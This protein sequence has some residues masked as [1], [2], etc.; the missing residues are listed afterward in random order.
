MHKQDILKI[1]AIKSNAPN[2]WMVYKRQQNITNKEI[3]LTKQA[4]YQNSF[5]EHPGYSQKTWQTINE[6]TSRKSGKMSVTSLKINGLMITD[7]REISNKFNNH[8]STISPKLASEIDSDSG[9]Y[10][11]Y[12][13][14]TDK[15]FHLHPTN[16]SKVFSLMNKLNKLKQT[17]KLNKFKATSISARLIRECA[18][19]ICVPICHIFNQSISQGKLPEDWKSARVTPF[20]KQG[21]QDDVNNYPPRS[22]R[23][24]FTNNYMPI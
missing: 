20:F 18:N 12:L 21:D 13:T 8:F 14:C 15:Q 7:T 6:L 23:E 2:D 19:L 4:Y 22:L 17:N 16:T 1:K 10:Q 5:N 24:S 11:R 9:D 3:R